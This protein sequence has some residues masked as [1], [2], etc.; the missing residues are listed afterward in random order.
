MAFLLPLA[1][2]PF[3]IIYNAFILPKRLVLYLG[4]AVLIALK[5]EKLKEVPWYLQLLIALNVL[6]LFYTWNPYYTKVAAVL[7][8]S[9]YLVMFFVIDAINK[10]RLPLLMWA[11]AVSG[12]IIAVYCF[13][14][15][16][17]EDVIFKWNQQEDFAAVGTIGNTNYLGF[18]LIFPLFA[19][20]GLSL[21][22]KSRFS[23]I[24]IAVLFIMFLLAKARASW[25]SF[26]VGMIVFI[27]VYPPI[28]EKIKPLIL[29]VLAGIFVIVLFVGIYDEKND[30][31]MEHK[32]LLK[33]ETIKYRVKKYVP[34]AVWLWKQNPFFGVGLWSYRKAVYEAQAQIEKESPGFFADYDLPKPRRVH[35]D[36][37]E[38]LV[39]GGIVMAIAMVILFWTVISHGIKLYRYTSNPLI[40]ACL[41]TI[42][43]VLVE[44]IFFFPFRVTSTMFMIF[45]TMGVIEG[46]YQHEF[47]KK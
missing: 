4:V 45:L 12:L 21:H 46:C 42:L 5:P 6:S 41:C 28:R 33:V 34:G 2:D 29:A 11:I 39:D 1:V 26:S 44:A 30:F 36:Y 22:H 17:G 3:L 19:M 20:I 35:C 32:D 14:Q 18:Y 47:A 16:F 13:F 27:Y 23:I 40:L 31:Y 15:Y 9:C 37:L 38:V 8:I 24:G 25:V 43:A 10:E 7:N